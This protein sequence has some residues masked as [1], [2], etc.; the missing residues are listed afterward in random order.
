MQEIPELL[1]EVPLF[2]KFSNEDVGALTTIVKRRSY[3]KAHVLFH[4]G[5]PGEEF[6]VL[7]EGSVKVELMNQDGKELTLAI[8]KPYQFLG[9]LA[10]LDDVPRSAT[11]VTMEKTDFLVINKRDFA[12]MLD[13]YPRM[14]FP[15]LR[16][17]TRRVRI[18][19]DDIA[20][21]AFLDSY[22]RVSRKI[23]ALAEE[24]GQ[25]H[26]DGSIYIDQALTHQQL[27]NLVGTT[28]ETVT[29]ILNEM[30]DR[31][32]ISIRRHR[33]TVV[34]PEELAERANLGGYT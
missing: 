16:Q 34:D 1:R 17:L 4:Q 28:R 15:M 3:P 2:S 13:T 8:L 24:M 14:C 31:D 25:V 18:L 6:L 32:L 30:K 23:L 5:D 19:T 22:A 33:I 27:A 7:T 12:R 20:S 10:L 29:K 11:V 21:M 26:E 9:E